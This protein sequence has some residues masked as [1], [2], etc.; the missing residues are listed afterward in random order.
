MSSNLLTAHFLTNHD[1]LN[2]P[3]QVINF[4]GRYLYELISAGDEIIFSRQRNPA[5]QEEFFNISGSH[6]KLSN[7]SAVVGQNGVGKSTILNSIRQHF[8]EKPNALPFCNSVMLF[9]NG[10]KLTYSSNEENAMVCLQEDGKRTALKKMKKSCVGTIFYS[11]HLD[12]KYNPNFDEVDFHDISL[13]RYLELDLVDLGS[14]GTNDNGIDYPIKQELLFKNSRRQIQFLNSG[15]VTQKKIFD[16]LIVFPDHGNA[17][18]ITRDTKFDKNSRNVPVA[19]LTPLTELRGQ[20]EKDLD[21]WTEVRKTDKNQRVTNQAIINRFLLQRHM[22]RNLLSVLIRQMDIS[23]QYR[24]DCKFDHDHFQ[25]QRGTD[26]LTGLLAFLQSCSIPTPKGM[27]QPFDTDLIAKLFKKLYEVTDLISDEHFIG[28]S[29]FSTS[30]EDATKLLEIQNEVIFNISNYYNQQ[31][32][33]RPSD[34]QRMNYLVPGFL[35][36]TPAE[37]HLSSG[38]NALLNFFSKLYDFLQEKRNPAVNP[39]E[40]VRTYILLLDEADLGFHPLWKKKY[41]YILANTLPYFFEQY[42]DIE[43]LQ[44]IFTTHDPLTLSDLPNNNVTYL[45]LEEDSIRI[46]GRA[47]RRPTFGANIT[48]LLADSFFIDDALV[49]DF[50]QHKIQSVVEWLN[51]IDKDDAAK[52]LQVIEMI[53]E[54]VVRQKFS[55]MYD[56]KMNTNLE[57]ALINKQLEELN[58][59]RSKLLDDRNTK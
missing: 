34:Y 33:E 17:S 16:G 2:Y 11:P 49:G 9:E 56:E 7:V 12:L 50:A 54:P 47:E 19:F 52:Y 22:V 32:S 58:L 57:L 29:S 6:K 55:E 39:P 53:D 27:V 59:R 24:S 42:R 4:G 38:E 36:Y 31:W 5:F 41:L 8:I 40:D 15:L 14:R 48:D 28:T 51:S 1:Y 30:P 46:L 45:T 3:E 25:T 10:D 20:I 37:R 13:D 21:K 26:S 35:Y 18:F 43:S 23:N 44:L